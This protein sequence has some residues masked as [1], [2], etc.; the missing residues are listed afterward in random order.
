M[1]GLL[2]AGTAVESIERSGIHI[3]RTSTLEEHRRRYTKSLAQFLDVGLVE[4][5]SFVQN[6]GDDAF[7]TE[8]RHQVLLTKVIR[9]H[10]PTENVDGSIIWDRLMLV[11]IPFE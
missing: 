10:Q 7:R 5:A 9:I 2:R 1:E 8:D 6:F 4:F 11:F 3:S